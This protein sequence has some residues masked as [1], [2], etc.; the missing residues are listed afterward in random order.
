MTEDIT[1]PDGAKYR[2]KYPDSPFIHICDLVNKKTGKTGRETNAEKTHQIPVGT[3]V[4]L[5]SGVRL[6]VVSHDRDC[7]QTPLYGLCHDKE[8]TVVEREGFANRKWDHGY[9]EESLTVI[10]QD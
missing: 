5:E 2:P 10:E 8:D 9:S 7:D 1:L 6:F 3:L 4:E